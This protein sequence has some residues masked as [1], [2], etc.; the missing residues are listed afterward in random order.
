M[1]NKTFGPFLSFFWMILILMLTVVQ[2]V[3]A[4]VSSSNFRTLGGSIGFAP[5]R[6]NINYDV[7]LFSVDYSQSFK[8]PKKKSFLTWYAQPQFNLVKAA[9]TPKN[10][11]DYEFGLNL[12]IRNYIKVNDDLYIYDM[13]C[14]GPHFMSAIMPL[15]ARGFLFSDNLA[16]G[17]LICIKQKYFLRLQAG[18]RHLSNAG[19]KEPNK[20][21]DSFL[22]MVGLSEIK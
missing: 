7:L 22:F 14:S 19:I 20:G 11:L 16:F 18:I 5:G 6:N 1:K 21:I 13:I 10:A 2:P 4:Q 17:S 15:Q 9:G 8:T 12:G 3:S